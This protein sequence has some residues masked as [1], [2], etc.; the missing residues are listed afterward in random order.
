[1]VSGIYTGPTSGG[2]GRRSGRVW[3]IRRAGCLRRVWCPWCLWRKRCA[4]SMWGCGRPWADRCTGARGVAGACG[5]AGACGVSGVSG[6]AGACGVSGVAGAC[7]I[8]GVA[9]TAGA[10]GVVRRCRSVRS[11]WSRGDSRSLWGFGVAGACGVS[12]VSGVAGACGVSG[13]VGAC[14]ISGVSG[15]SGAGLLLAA[16]TSASGAINTTETVLETLTVVAGSTLAVGTLVRIVLQGTC[17]ATVADTSTFTVRAGTAGTTSDASVAAMT[18]TSANVGN[19]R[20]VQNHHRSHCENYGFGG[21]RGG[22]DGSHQPRGNGT[23]DAS[24]QRSAVHVIYAGH[25]DRD[26]TLYHVQI[27]CHHVHLHVPDRDD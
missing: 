2:G 13:V 25:Y 4:R 6:T 26:Q 9:G 27:L 3:S 20:A 12:G 15:V 18:L 14:G 21:D 5:I 24:N 23:I 1:M 7:G 16:A 10:C 8:S 19:Q 11:K 17:T 22:F